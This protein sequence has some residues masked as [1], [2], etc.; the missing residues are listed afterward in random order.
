MGE[1]GFKCG[2]TGCIQPRRQTGSAIFLFRETVIAR[3]LQGLDQGR[4]GLVRFAVRVEP[5][6]IETLGRIGA[7]RGRVAAQLA[8][9]RRFHR[10]RFCRKRCDYQSSARWR[11]TGLRRLGRYGFLFCVSGRTTRQCKRDSHCDRPPHAKNLRDHP[12]TN[13]CLIVPS[14]TE[15]CEYSITIIGA[16]IKI[17]RVSPKFHE[18]ITP[19]RRLRSG[20]HDGVIRSDSRCRSLCCLSATWQKKR[21]MREG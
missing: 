5:K 21:N 12:V 6:R 3:A 11:L 9:Q 19:T 13:C 10:L 8:L 14:P 2:S 7:E 18:V 17:A 15:Y 4:S 1:V 16:S 20:N